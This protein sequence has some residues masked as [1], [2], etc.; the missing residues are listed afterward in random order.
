MPHDVPGMVELMGGKEEVIANL[1]NLFDHTPSDML[2]NDYYNH[3]NEPVHFVPFLLISWMYLGIHR[4]GH[5]IF[6]KCLCEQ[7]RRDCW[8]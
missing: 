2:W 6:V 5:D 1:T 4:S 8:Q 7:S 3:A